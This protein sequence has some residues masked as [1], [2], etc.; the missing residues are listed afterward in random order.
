MINCTFTGV[1]TRRASPR[2]LLS[3]SALAT[4]SCPLSPFVLPPPGGGRR[5]LLLLLIVFYPITLFSSSSYHLVLDK[6]SFRPF[7]CVRSAAN[8]YR[9]LSSG[10]AGGRV[11]FLIVFFFSPSRPHRN[12]NRLPAYESSLSLVL[13]LVFCTISCL[14]R[15]SQSLTTTTTIPSVSPFPP[16]RAFCFFS[17]PNTRKAKSRS[18]GL[19]LVCWAAE[20]GGTRHTR[21]HARARARTHT[22]RGKGKHTRTHAHRLQIRQRY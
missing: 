12:H 6:A 1:F 20:G 19:W 21:T 4:L 11:P 9:F 17:H 14:A 2:F 15:P 3:Y 18:P 7:F 5:L 22:Q 8:K 16:L 13:V 10:L